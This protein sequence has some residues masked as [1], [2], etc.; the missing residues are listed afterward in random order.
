MTGDPPFFG[1]IFL[2]T[3][4]SLDLYGLDDDSDVAGS[5]PDFLVYLALSLGYCSMFSAEF[6]TNVFG[7]C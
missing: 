3:K 5:C 2:S 1:M 4:F 6:P 7:G